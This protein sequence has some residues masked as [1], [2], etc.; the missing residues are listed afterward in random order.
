M[1]R[2]DRL[3]VGSTPTPAAYEQL[4]EVIRPDEEPVPKT[5]GGYEPL[6]SSSL[7]A[8]AFDRLGLI[9]QQE[10]VGSARRKSECNS[11]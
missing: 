10:D 2:S 8:S 9:V 4:T 6:V 1:G 3:D 11:R 5:G 7:T